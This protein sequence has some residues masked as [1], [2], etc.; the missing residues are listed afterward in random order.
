MF[1]CHSETLCIFYLYVC[2]NIHFSPCMT[3]KRQTWPVSSRSS[4]MTDVVTPGSASSGI[5][6]TSQQTNLWPTFLWKLT[7]MTDS[8]THTQQRGWPKD[9]Q[10]PNSTGVGQQWWYELVRSTGEVLIHS[11]QASCV[12]SYAVRQNM[13]SPQF[14]VLIL[15]S[16]PPKNPYF[17]SFSKADRAS[18]YLFVTHILCILSIISAKPSVNVY[19]VLVLKA[20][21]AYPF[22]S[23]SI[24]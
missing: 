16:P 11:S 13:N 14:V 24:L 22:V 23:V 2:R 21:F 3:P 4:W 17:N 8:C 5:G 6:G 12:S 20:I 9:W 10:Q 7:G 1:S 15:F 18:L 19:A